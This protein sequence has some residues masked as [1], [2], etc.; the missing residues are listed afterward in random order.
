MRKA[1]FGCIV[2][3]SEAFR[4]ERSP[5]ETKYSPEWASLWNSQ[6]FNPT[7]VGNNPGRKGV[8]P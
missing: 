3:D 6:H 2:H 4:P 5:W 8:P 7:G 1:N